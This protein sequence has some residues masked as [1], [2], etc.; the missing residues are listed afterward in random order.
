MG[1]TLSSRRILAVFAAAGAFLALVL[2]MTLSGASA[3]A[4]VHRHA[5]HPARHHLAKKTTDSAGPTDQDNVQ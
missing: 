3:R 4:A 2:A 1:P 5:V